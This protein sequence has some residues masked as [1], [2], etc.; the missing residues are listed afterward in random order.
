MWSLS[1]TRIAVVAL[2]GALIAGSFTTGVLANRSASGKPAIAITSRI[3]TVND[4]LQAVNDAFTFTVKPRNFAFRKGA[5]WNVY[6]DSFNPAKPLGADYVTSGTTSKVRVSSAQLAKA[7]A[8]TGTHTLYVV[9]AKNKASLVRPLTAASTV[10]RFGRSIV[11][12]EKGTLAHPIV[13]P[14]SGGVTFHVAVSGFTLSV[15]SM[16]K[17]EI[18]SEGHYHAYIDTVDPDHPFAHYVSCFCDPPVTQPAL[19]FTLNA[20]F[21]AKHPGVGPGLHTLYVTL[22]SNFHS[23]V[24]PLTGDSTVIDI[25]G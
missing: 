14:A 23:L 13:I 3:G 6:V 18:P 16:N 25:Q 17:K 9:L 2:T 11:L 19:S 20:A 22:N 10:I 4:P 21:L 1:P 8:T 24:A 12:E 7:G 5:R 15:A